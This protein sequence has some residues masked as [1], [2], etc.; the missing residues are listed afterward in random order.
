M[1]R[2]LAIETSSARLSLAVGTEAAVLK[3][4]HGPLA[5]RHAESLF[6]GMEKLLKQVRWPVQSL[7]GVLVSTGPGSFTG[8]RIGLAAARALG[9]SLKIPVQGISSLETL[10]QGVFKSEGLVCPVID[11]LRGDVFTALYQRGP[12]Q[13]LKTLWKERRLSL[14]D[15][16]RQLKPFKRNPLLFAGDAAVIHKEQLRAAAGSR[17]KAVPDQDHYPRAGVLLKIGSLRLGK[18]TTASYKQVLPLYLRSAAAQERQ[19]V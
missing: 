13:R 10:A 9:Q 15:L 11:A 2:L 19:K 16:T 1:R 14:E 18:R 7:T 6:E 5:W 8:I 17:W 4:F 3:E 12:D